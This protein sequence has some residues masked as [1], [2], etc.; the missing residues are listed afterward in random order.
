MTRV[1]AG[2]E[3]EKGDAMWLNNPQDKKGIFPK[4]SRPW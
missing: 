4:L 3:L 2:N 1:V